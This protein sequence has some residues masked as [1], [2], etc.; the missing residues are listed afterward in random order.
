MEELVAALVSMG[1]GSCCSRFDSRIRYEDHGQAVCHLSEG[2]FRYR[3]A[4]VP[5]RYPCWGY[6]DRVWRSRRSPWNPHGE[7]PPTWP[8][9]GSWPKGRPWLSSAVW[10]GLR[11]QAWW[12]ILPQ[13]PTGTWSPGRCS[14][15]P[16]RPT[17]SAAPWL[18]RRS[19]PSAFCRQR[20]QRNR[21]TVSTAGQLQL[22]RSRVAV[23]GCGGL[24]G[25]VIEQ[26]HALGS[27]IW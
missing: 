10:G 25:Y 26:L 4:G 14:I 1:R 7:P 5:D 13:V 3:G 16:W 19:F 2:T 27:G 12:S 20:Y 17:A 24:G 23:V 9:N 15:R 22:F 21:Q 6:R 8:W 18:R 11:W